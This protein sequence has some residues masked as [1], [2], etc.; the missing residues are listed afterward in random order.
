MK[1]LLCGLIGIWIISGSIIAVAQDLS[2]YYNEGVD[3]SKYGN[4]DE[5]VLIWKQGFKLLSARGIH[6]PRI[7]IAMLEIVTR[8]KLKKY[9]EDASRIYLWGLENPEMEKHYET[10]KKEVEMVS[11]LLFKEEQEEWKELIEAKD[12]DVINKI[13]E[14]WF[15]HDPIP[16]TEVN[17]RLIEHWE[18]INFVRHSLINNDGEKLS[19]SKSLSE[20]G[21]RKNTQVE[22]FTTN[23]NSVYGTDDRGVIYVKFGEPFEIKTQNLLAGADFSLVSFE[24]QQKLQQYVRY[25]DYTIWKYRNIIPGETTLFI[26]GAKE[27]STYGL[28]NSLD[29]FVP[30]RTYRNTPGRNSSRIPLGTYI[31]M[32]VYYENREFDKHFKRRYYE[33]LKMLQQNSYPTLLR[34]LR[35][36]YINEDMFNAVKLYGPQEL[37]DIEMFIQPL[38]IIFTQ[39]RLLN[40]NN[41]PQ[42][43]VTALSYLDNEQNYGIDE[44]VNLSK[45]DHYTLIHTLI[46]RDSTLNQLDRFTEVPSTKFGYS[47]T[48]NMNQT[49]QESYFTLVAEMYDPQKSASL[50]ASIESGYVPYLGKTTFRVKPP[51][52]PDMTKLELSDLIIGYTIPEEINAAEFPFPVVPSEE[53]PEDENLQIYLE[54]YH[55]TLGADSRSKYTV[56]FRVAK[57][58]KPGILARIRGQKENKELLSQTYT[59]DSAS[60]TARDNVTFDISVLKDGD[61]EFEVEVT[62]ILSN[63]TKLREGKFKKLK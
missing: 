51:L 4:Y 23:M 53:I 56:E 9:Y 41:Q 48:F 24:V 27:G 14:F 11:P 22:G 32:F 38:D 62:D 16:V 10:F 19:I 50:K 1:R 26:F 40:D 45:L 44:I 8:N 3:Q 63:R 49:D 12:P 18:R 13:R 7:G 31:Q 6:D 2:F 55:L 46:T 21:I 5:A 17:E 34:D 36:R 35:S 29:E 57:S 58:G 47:S 42:I 61:Y 60:T 33:I 20:P 52:D 37:S 28:M 15:T 54:T 43:A 30:T 39:N 59:F 25:D